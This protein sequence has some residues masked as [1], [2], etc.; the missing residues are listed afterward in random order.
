[1]NERLK[2]L[3]CGQHHTNNLPNISHHLLPFVGFCA[4]FKIKIYRSLRSYG[5]N[6]G[7]TIMTIGDRRAKYWVPNIWCVNAGYV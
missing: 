7:R 3:H 1:M 2:G 5:A 6:I 4:L